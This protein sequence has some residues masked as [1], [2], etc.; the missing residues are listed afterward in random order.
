MAEI[1]QP[2]AG[3]LSDKKS[4]RKKLAG[5]VV[6]YNK[7]KYAKLKAKSKRLNAEKRNYRPAA[8]RTASATWCA[9]AGSRVAGMICSRVGLR[10]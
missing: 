3:R 6:C 1:K 2:Q 7:N 9:T 8:A 10:K 4:S 5:A